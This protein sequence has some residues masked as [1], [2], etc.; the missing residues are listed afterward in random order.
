MEDTIA[1]GEV[2]EY[3]WDHRNRL[4]Q[5]VKK[6]AQGAV[7]ETVD[8]EYDLFDR[9]IEKTVTPQVGPASLSQYVYDGDHLALRF[10]SGN[11]AA[12]YLYGPAVDMILLS[13][14]TFDTT[15]VSQDS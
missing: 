5:V 11:L 2:V 9:K 6:D 3:S 10:E 8:I 14:R 15:S 12:R 1:T 13:D 7:I 4:V